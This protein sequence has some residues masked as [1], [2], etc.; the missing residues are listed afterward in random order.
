V[1]R[2]T[3]KVQA[4]SYDGIPLFSSSFLLSSPIV[5]VVSRDITVFTVISLGSAIILNLDVR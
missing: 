4:T 3:A 5:V 1:N 2:A